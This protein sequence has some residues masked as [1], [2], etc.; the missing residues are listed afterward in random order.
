MAH[1]QYGCLLQKRLQSLLGKSW[2][3]KYVH[4]KQRSLRSK[5]HPSDRAHAGLNTSACQ[6]PLHKPCCTQTQ[7]WD[8][9]HTAAR[10]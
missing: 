7:A 3:Y 6:T 2:G 1:K 10:A 4:L 5:G 8:M 9:M